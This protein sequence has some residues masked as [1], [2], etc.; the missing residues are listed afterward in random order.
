MRPSG[1]F[2]DRMITSMRSEALIRWRSMKTV[3]PTR[4]A[5]RKL[6]THFVHNLVTIDAKKKG[7]HRCRPLVYWLRGPANEPGCIGFRSLTMSGDRAGAPLPASLFSELSTS[8]P[9]PTFDPSEAHIRGI[10]YSVD[11]SNGRVKQRATVPYSAQQALGAAR[12]TLQ[13]KVRLIL[14]ARPRRRDITPMQNSCTVLA[15]LRGTASIIA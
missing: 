7:L 5:R 2:P 6:A 8:D 14:A 11:R 12:T 1:S 15:A 9:L 10:I 13:P 3:T 4:R